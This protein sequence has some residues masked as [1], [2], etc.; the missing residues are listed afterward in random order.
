MSRN[1]PCSL[2]RAGWMCGSERRF[3]GLR[4]RPRVAVRLTGGRRGL[5]V[6]TPA[7][8][9]LVARAVAGTLPVAA[10][11]TTTAGG[12]GDLGGGVAEGGA[13][14]VDLDLEHGALL[15]RVRLVRPRLEP[16]GDDDLHALLE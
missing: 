7:A 9:A 1:V 14:L 16:A 6:A 15:A 5:L 4:R 12:L 2:T 3:V 13:D 11:L 8:A 10:A